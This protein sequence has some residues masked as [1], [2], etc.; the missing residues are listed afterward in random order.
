MRL[1]R[2]LPLSLM[3]S[4]M[5]CVAVGNSWGQKA[6]KVHIIYP[7]NWDSKLAKIEIP[8]IENIERVVP[9][10][11]PSKQ[12]MRNT[13]YIVET[14]R[15]K[16]DGKRYIILTDHQSLEH[17]GALKRLAKHHK[18]EILFSKD[19][20]KLYQDAA[21]FERLKSELNRLDA[22]YVAI[23]PQEA[24]YRENMLLG[25]F[26][27]LA[28]LDD[29]NELD[30]YPG[31]LYAS[32]AESFEKLIT[33]S[34]NHKPQTSKRLSP[35]ASCMVPNKK[36]LRS[37]Q[38]NAIIH[39]LFAKY[40]HDAPILNLYTARA[41]GG[42]ELS[43]SK[44]YRMDMPA[45]KFAKQLP[46]QIKKVVD[47]SSLMVLHGHGLPGVSCGLDI[48][49]FADG[50][51]PDV[52]LCGS[53][54]SA[55]VQQSDLTE[56]KISPDGF[57]I[58]PRKAFAVNAIDNGSTV[59]FGHMRLN[60]GFPKLYPVLETFLE[61]RTVGE[62]YQELINACLKQGNFSSKE[63]A[64]EEKPENARRIK[65]NALLYVL[66]GDPALQPLKKIM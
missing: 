11:R 32:D 58:I 66:F 50:V 49:A 2:L 59:V 41:Q 7:Q 46:D 13:E 35:L 47:N 34:V 6:E 28:N 5:M 16:V 48:D 60:N 15:H 23:A 27:L 43:G 64:V 17:V 40:G 51:S 29:D 22:K 36:E 52:V 10:N 62:A 56:M 38:K 1:K 33:R 20:S 61:G 57:P 42:P 26:E 39:N 19:L 12:S 54:F 14:E 3:A 37:L 9:G 65:Q 53:C 25:V 18:G 8:E 44:T 4:A 55:S 21:E 45:R 30:V 31:V 63:L 24:S